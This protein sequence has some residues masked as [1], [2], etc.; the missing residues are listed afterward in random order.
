MSVGWDSAGWALALAGEY[1]G[2]GSSIDGSGREGE[3]FFF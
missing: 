2:D 3:S 1:G